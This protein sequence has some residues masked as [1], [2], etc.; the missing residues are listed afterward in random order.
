MKTIIATLGFS[1]IAAA[2]AAAQS[3]TYD[4]EFTNRCYT[5]AAVKDSTNSGFFNCNL[6]LSREAGNGGDRRAASLV[7]RGI[8]FLVANNLPA[9]GR[10]FDQ[11]LA[12]DPTQPE[13]LLGKAIERWQ[14]GANGE[15]VTLASQA[16]EYRPQ[17]PAVAYFVRG[18]ANERLGNV[19][20]AY[21]D[22]TTARRLEPR[23]GEPQAQLQRYKVI[24]RQ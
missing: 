6:A 23:W 12:V 20:A 9:A 15:A 22:L 2:P 17:R 24:I 4:M 18:L 16:I 5:A 7:N 21:A 13:A 19:S 10:D 3:F 8:L 14:A 11:A 1:M